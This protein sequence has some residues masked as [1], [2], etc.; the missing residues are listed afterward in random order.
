MHRCET[1]PVQLIPMIQPH[2][3]LLVAEPVPDYCLLQA[4]GNVADLFGRPLD[5]LL[6]TSLSDLLGQDWIE[7]LH[8]A[9]DCQLACA[10]VGRVFDLGIGDASR[11]FHA[12]LHLGDD[13]LLMELEPIEDSE[14]GFEA[15][16]FQQRMQQVAAV[17]NE[18]HDLVST[19]ELLAKLTQQIAGYERVMVYQFDRDW[20][21]RVIAEQRAHADIPS[22]LGHR[23]PAGDI[24]PQVRA[25]YLRQPFRLLV[26]I[27]AKAAPLQPAINPRQSVPLD[28]TAIT[29]RGCSPV[30]IEYLRNMG[31][32]ASLSVALIVEGQLWGL[33]ACHHAR[34]RNL[35]LPR[36]EAVKFLGLLAAMRFAALIAQER[37]QMA[38]KTQQSIG[39][40]LDLFYRK[41]PQAPKLLRFEQHL[42][43]LI[44][45]TGILIRVK[46]R[47]FR[48]GALPSDAE[49]D[50]LLPW[51]DQQPADE[52][53]AIDALGEV[54][55]EATRY[56]T[57]AAGVLAVWIDR[58]AGDSILWFRE[59]RVHHVHWAGNPEKILVRDH[60]GRP[61]ISPRQS[62][63]TWTETWLGRCEPWQT[64]EI[65][66][67]GRA[68]QLMH[69]AF[70]LL[71]DL[72]LTLNVSGTDA[73]D[74]RPDE[75]LIATGPLL[76]N[77]PAGVVVHAADTQILY[78]NPL[79][80]DLLRMTE[81]QVLGRQTLRPEWNLI[82]EAGHRISAEDY[83]ANRVLSTGNPVSGLVLG[84][85]DKLEPEPTWLLIQA[86][87]Q[88][89]ASGEHQAIVT[90]VDIS[91]RERIPFRQIVDLANDAVVV[92]EAQPLDPPGPRIL[93]SNQAHAKLTGYSKE[94]VQGQTPRLF[95]GPNTDRDTLD[96]MRLQLNRG[97]PVREILVNYH[98]SGSSYWV[99]ISITPLYDHRGQLRYFFAIERD[100]TDQAQE[101]QQ[102][103]DAADTD[104]LTGLLN[105]RG[106]AARM[107]QLIAEAGDQPLRCA[108]IAADLDHFKRINDQ[109]G[110]ETGDQ[111]LQGLAK[112]MLE[113]FRRD[114]LCARF[115]GEEF[116]VVLLDS[117]LEEA[118]AVAERLRLQ[119]ESSLSA[120]D[121]QP[122]TVSLGVTVWCSGDTE[123]AL[124]ARADEALYGA[125]RAGRN[126]VVSCTE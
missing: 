20:E 78:A 122:I 101:N 90:F 11:L 12:T 16:A 39:S 26:D 2:G 4:S 92:T 66:L 50:Q 49:L 42:T 111:V 59:E 47:R 68:A 125:K 18:P 81:E 114:D 102:L 71:V 1:E 5:E 69:Q 120:P 23:F 95:Q 43:D 53:L 113:V 108:A 84:I 35:E 117:G 88:A 36:R 82:D 25:L 93:Y 6:G 73:Q 115:G 107:Q 94:N 48:R 85:V 58:A 51:L 91:D 32:R 14:I 52:V 56:A 87:P 45:A 65:E 67:A 13:L 77:L 75:E 116:I 3:F 10:P 86:Y 124:L 118:Q 121:A 123:T 27:D 64:H 119:V 83:P 29:L 62:F 46:A 44:A 100:V 7:A 89:D 96:R 21:G 9:S 41:G 61:N 98:Q 34:P 22:Y 33:I 19:A 70:R 37:D 80:L 106:F 30:H 8:Q 57:Q 105:R 72:S 103:R 54:F 24:P 60:Q 63:S 104:A 126:Q 97:E 110:H 76:Q 28:L 31:V 38:R 40:M 17:L 55:P 74:S 79:A 15:I 112:V 99:D 109:F